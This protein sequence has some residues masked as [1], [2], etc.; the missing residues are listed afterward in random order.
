MNDKPPLTPQEIFEYKN[1]W[2]GINT[3]QV[4]IDSYYWSKDYCKKNFVSHSWHIK[5]FT[6]QD[7]SHTVSF[8]KLTDKNKFCKAYR[9]H[10]PV[11]NEN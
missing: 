5:R 4:D 8:A 3:V 1:N 7:D 2:K 9:A 11:F 10:N 6:G